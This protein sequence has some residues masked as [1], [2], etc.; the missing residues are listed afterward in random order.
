MD[1]IVNIAF[2][3][4]FVGTISVVLLVGLAA[5]RVARWLYDRY[6]WMRWFSSW[7]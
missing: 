3:F 6:L 4:V 7:G 2:L 1:T 5:F